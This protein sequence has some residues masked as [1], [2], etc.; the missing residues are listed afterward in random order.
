MALV[1]SVLRTHQEV[2]RADGDHVSHPDGGVQAAADRDPETVSA[3]LL[4]MC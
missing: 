1:F 4:L 2:I 3:V